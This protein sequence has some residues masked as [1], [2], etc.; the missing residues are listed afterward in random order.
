M[1]T[2]RRVSWANASGRK[3]VR[4]EFSLQVAGRQERKL[5]ET[6]E[7]ADAALADRQKEVRDGKIYGVVAKAFGQ[8]AGDYV[9]YKK[10]KGKR[11]VEEDE[12]ILKRRLLP[13]FGAA[14]KVS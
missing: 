10:A 4:Y 9:A 5:F 6:R 11:S 13:F 7:E 1:A 12:E 14:T 8:V 2:V 3:I